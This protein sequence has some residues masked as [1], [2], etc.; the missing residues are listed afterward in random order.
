MVCFGWFGKKKKGKPTGWGATSTLKEKFDDVASRPPHHRD[1]SYV[2]LE[3]PLL[4]SSG[5]A[6]RA[7]A[8]LPPAIASLKPTAHPGYSAYAGAADGKGPQDGELRHRGAGRT[9]A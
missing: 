1:G 8:A 5:P 9:A 3:K 7:T 6:A 4:F 2:S